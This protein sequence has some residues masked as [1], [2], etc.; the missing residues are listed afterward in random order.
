MRF[1]EQRRWER[2]FPVRYLVVGE[3]KE[4]GTPLLLGRCAAPPPVVIHCTGT[5]GLDE[6]YFRS[7]RSLGLL[8]T[9]HGPVRLVH[10]VFDAT[11]DEVRHLRLLE[12][13]GE[14]PENAEAGKVSRRALSVN[15]WDIS[16]QWDALFTYTPRE[17]AVPWAEAGRGFG[18]RHAMWA[19]KM[20]NTPE[21]WEDAF[22]VEEAGAAAAVADGASTGIYCRVWADQLCK[23]FL[24]ERPD[25]RDPAALNKW[26]NGLRS[27]WRAAID[28]GNLNWSKKA[29]VDQVGA[30]ATLLGLELGPA[31]EGGG[32]PWRAFAVGDAC[33]FWVRDDR[34][35]ASFPVVAADQFG[36]APLLVRSS[37]GFKTLAVAAAGTCLPGDRFLLATD[38]V[39]ARLFKSMAGGPGPEWGRFE[40]ISEGEW[41]EELDTLRTANDMVNDD[42]TL[43]V[44]KVRDG[45]EEPAEVESPAEETEL[46]APTKTRDGGVGAPVEESAPAQGPTAAD[47]EQ[48]SREEVKEA[49]RGGHLDEP[50][51]HQEQGADTPRPPE[52]PS[53][54]AEHESSTEHQDGFPQPT[55]PRP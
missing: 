43:V 2:P 11:N 40:T 9:S 29:K 19:Q 30:A 37:P 7:A 33:L 42:C 48:P 10:H 31:D 16:D 39:A 35:L 1:E 46:V 52:E 41:R 36:S 47:P 3:D 24:S 49:D 55:D 26:V 50:V 32:R 38:A 4:D 28:Y 21:Q 18:R 44:L 23:R 20:G 8:A 25:V 54:P 27:E 34:S 53:P 15:D 14:F 51:S 45:V 17:D 22:A 5:E 6:A 13:S 12:V